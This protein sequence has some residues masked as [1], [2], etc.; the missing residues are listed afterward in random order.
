[1]IQSEA[2]RDFWQ[3]L[4]VF[5][6]FFGRKKDTQPPVCLIQYGQK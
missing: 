5:A 1:M 6:D 2:A 3:P 4:L